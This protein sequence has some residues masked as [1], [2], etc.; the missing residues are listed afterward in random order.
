MGLGGFAK[1]ITVG[2][3]ADVGLN[4]LRVLELVF[5]PVQGMRSVTAIQP[6]NQ[7]QSKK[8]LTTGSDPRIELQIRNCIQRH[9]SDV[10]RVTPVGTQR[11][12]LKG[13]ARV[14]STFQI[15]L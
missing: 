9:A 12:I 10:Y 5:Y 1:V 13:I 2:Q 15:V 7:A 14:A 4:N 11:V 8:V 6:V 3:R